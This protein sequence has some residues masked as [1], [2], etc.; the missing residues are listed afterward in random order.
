MRQRCVKRP[1]I[2]DVLD[3]GRWGVSTVVGVGDGGRVLIVRTSRGDDE[4]VERAENGWWVR[5]RTAD[6]VAIPAQERIRT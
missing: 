6:G 5:L 1:H 3:I 4:S 2:G